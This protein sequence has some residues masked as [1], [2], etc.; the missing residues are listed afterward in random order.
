MIKKLTVGI[1]QETKYGSERRAPLI[2]KDVR[3]L[4][5]HGISV[6]VET[7]P[8]RIFRDVEYKNAGAKIVQKFKSASLLVGIK[9]PQIRD[10]HSNTIYMLFS[11]VAKGQFQNMPLLKEF[12]HK[13]ITLIDYEKIT[14]AKGHRL[15]YFGRFAGI[16][17]L[18][19]SLY[20]L[21]KKLEW[22]RARNP[23]SIIRPSYQYDSLEAIQHDFERL[24]HHIYRRGFD[25]KIVPFMIGITGYGNVSKGA[26][27]MLALL[28]PIEIHPHDMLEFLRKRKFLHNRIYKIIF[29]RQGL[30]RSKNGEGFYFNDYLMH[31]K[32]FESNL[33]AYLPYLTMLIHGSYWDSRFPQL[34]TEEMIQK[35]HRKGF[36]LKF[37]NDVSCDV[38][39]GIE[40]TYKPTTIDNPTFTYR[41]KKK[42]FVE[43]HEAKGI[44]IMARDNLPA[45]LP[46]DAT[47]HFSTL[48]REYVYQV[49]SHGA[50]DITR[51]IE[52]P[53]EIRQAVITQNGKFAKNYNYLKKCL[54]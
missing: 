32:R 23:F 9:E 27:E 36:R 10:L 3:W 29:Y 25:K 45:E 44:S 33:D 40:L 2:P 46:K 19:N 39:G 41:V 43:G 1:L 48:I 8:V 5:K 12:L 4:V 18:V 42:D 13:K 31:P 26:Q 7:S 49:A 37:I 15:V 52:I 38:K 28:H 6:E 50:K 22:E 51:H 21:G 24:N 53:R 30:V 34:V 35:L 17:G 14:D 16:C 20:Y 11:H 47:C 54:W